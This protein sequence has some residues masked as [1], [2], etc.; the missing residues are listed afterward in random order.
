MTQTISHKKK[1][2]LSRDTILGRFF[3]NKLGM[4]GLSIVVLVGLIALF[5]PLIA[6]HSPE[7]TNLANTLQ[8]PSSTHLLGTDDLG[9]D[10]LSRLIFGAQTTV[11]AATQAT[12]ISIIG[13]V[14]LG[15]IA[16]YWGGAIDSV[17]SRIADAFM[18]FPALLLAVIIVGLTGPGLSN[19]MFAIGVVYAPRLFRITRSACIGIRPETFI[20]A[21]ETIGLRDTSIIIRHILPN[22]LSPLL[23]Q[24]SLTMAATVL[25]EASL[26]FLGLG[27]EPPEAS[28][29]SI[30]GR[31]V[32]FMTTQFIPVIAAGVA[33][34]TLVLS[35]NVAGDALRDSIGRK[36]A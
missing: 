23:V 19:A 18:A 15:L 27:V 14:P 1:K 16:G 2:P 28:W 24:I 17:L 30:L 9:R 26:S 25:A 34:F 7:L 10:V 13:G 11:L 12:L 4:V 21:S 31:S 29:G 33:I 22:V 6:P 5:A 36:K 3:S 20:R 8:K 35:F 32:P